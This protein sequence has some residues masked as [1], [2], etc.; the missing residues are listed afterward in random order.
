MPEL[1]SAEE[2]LIK[3]VIARLR[4]SHCHRQHSADRVNIMGTYDE[5]W[6]VGVECEGCSQAGMFVVSM[7]RDSSY[8]QVTD[9]AE[10]EEARFLAASS[11]SGGDVDQIRSFLRDFKGDFSSLFDGPK[12]A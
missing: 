10:H 4:C 12:D 7:R 5:V 6:I 3:R 2:R 1:P 11:I 8:E 9:L